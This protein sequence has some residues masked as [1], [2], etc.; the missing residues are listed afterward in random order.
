MGNQ[1][2]LEQGAV[3]KLGTWP[4]LTGPISFGINIPNATGNYYDGTPR[5]SDVL[6]MS[7][8]SVDAG[9]EVLW[10]DDHFSFPD[11]EDGV[12]GQWEAWTLMAA[13]SAEIPDVYL[14]PMVAC[15]AYRNPGVIAK[16]TEMIDEISGGKFI[17]G[18]GAGWQKD[19]YRQFG[20]R[21]EPRVS[22]F[23]EALHIIHGLLRDGEVD[24]QGEF[25][26]ANEAKNLPRGPREDGAPILIG[27]S[28]PRMLKLLARYADAWNTGGGTI[29]EVSEKIARLDAACEE[30][31]RD[32]KTVTR[33]IGHSLEVEDGAL[34]KS[35]DEH[36][37]K[38]RQYQGLGIDHVMFRIKHTT[39]ETIALTEPIIKAI[40]G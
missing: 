35:V 37:E 17:L 13:I 10:W 16:M 18:L 31:G 29:E 4:E 34:V 26:Q 36:V 40:R 28:S 14:G 12:R 19:E 20:I 8:A 39:P 9:Y 25:Y 24:Y 2:A 21:F 11:G 33:T 5:Y 15:T 3:R 7:R 1:E 27:S 6:A 23:A 30:A 22:Q 32:P 38:L